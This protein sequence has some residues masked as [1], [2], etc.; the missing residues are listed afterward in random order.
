MRNLTESSVRVWF[1]LWT[2]ERGGRG[3]TPGKVR[4]SYGQIA[5]ATGLSKR[6]VPRAVQQLIDRRYLR[7]VGGGIHRQESVYE[8]GCPSLPEDDECTQ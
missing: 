4:M 5:S 8:I 1:F 6:S 3:N 2:W 7:R